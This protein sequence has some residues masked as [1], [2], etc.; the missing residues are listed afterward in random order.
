MQ[1]CAISENPMS[2]PPIVSETT[3]VVLVAAVNG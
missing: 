3:R 2:L 1:P